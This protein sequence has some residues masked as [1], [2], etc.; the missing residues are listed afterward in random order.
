MPA[1]FFRAILVFQHGARVDTGTCA[2]LV[3][4]P[5]LAGVVVM[6]GHL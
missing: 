6:G 3:D 4:S 1:A 2:A 5:V